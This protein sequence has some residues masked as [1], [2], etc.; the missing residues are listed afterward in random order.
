MTL[1]ILKMALDAAVIGLSLWAF[2][3]IAAFVVNGAFPGSL[4]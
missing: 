4:A 3:R 2:T 1:R